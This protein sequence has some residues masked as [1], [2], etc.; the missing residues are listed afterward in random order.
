LS[1]SIW[2]TSKN[3]SQQSWMSCI[4]FTFMS[5]NLK[6]LLALIYESSLLIYFT[7]QMKLT[8]CFLHGS[9]NMKT[10]IMSSCAQTSNACMR[11]FST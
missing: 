2:K 10:T 11:I 9:L 4:V 8:T 7:R 1:F 5:L 6:P 3:S